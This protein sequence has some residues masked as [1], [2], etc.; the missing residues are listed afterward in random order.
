MVCLTA[1]KASITQ[2]NHDFIF[3]F[4]HATGN[5]VDFDGKHPL[6]SYENRPPMVGGV[7]Q[8]PLTIGGF[9]NSEVFVFAFFWFALIFFGFPLFLWIFSNKNFLVL[10]WVWGFGF[11]YEFWFSGIFAQFLATLL[12]LGM[13]RLLEKPLPLERKIVFLS[14]ILLTGILTHTAFVFLFFL[15]LAVHLAYA[16]R[17]KISRHAFFVVSLLTLGYGVLTKK[18]LFV[19]TLFADLSAPFFIFV[20]NNSWRFWLMLSLF[21]LAFFIELRIMT[22]AFILLLLN[23]V[24]NK[25]LLERFGLLDKVNYLVAGLAIIQL[26]LARTALCK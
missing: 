18:V 22:F 11:L 5:F 14:A 12:W 19:P 26:L 2:P 4:N 3:Y 23:V 17:E 24:E 15:T 9:F 13:L 21:I 6:S 8:L 10:L 16:F 7:S 1:L 20:E 25:G